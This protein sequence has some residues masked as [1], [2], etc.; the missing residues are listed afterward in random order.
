MTVKQAS[1]Y[2]QMDEHTDY[3]LARSGQIPSLLKSFSRGYTVL[4]IYP[5]CFSWV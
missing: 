5:N 1:D 2:L 3:K 4:Y